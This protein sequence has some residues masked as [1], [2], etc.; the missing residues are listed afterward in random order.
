MSTAE[1]LKQLDSQ[2]RRPLIPGKE[3][4]TKS[5]Y[6][7]HIVPA[8]HKPECLNALKYSAGA[9]FFPKGSTARCRRYLVHHR[10][11]HLA[12]S[13]FF[14]LVQYHPNH[15][16]RN[17][18]AVP[19]TTS[20]PSPSASAKTKPW[21]QSGIASGIKGTAELPS[22]RKCGKSAGLGRRES[23]TGGVDLR[24]ACAARDLSP[25]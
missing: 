16:A 20:P 9:P 11:L 3:Q 8:V 18:C 17:R 23:G 4:C 7:V 5:R 22:S 25:A 21:T 15:V 6:S 13:F 14:H 19:F 10:C 12:F 2:K 1:G 24:H